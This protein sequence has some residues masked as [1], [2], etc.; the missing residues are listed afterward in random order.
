ML[1]VSIKKLKEIGKKAFHPNC[2]NWSYLYLGRVARVSIKKTAPKA[3]FKL[4]Q[5][6]FGKKWKGKMLNGGSH[7]PINKI[8]A[9]VLINS[10]LEYSAKKNRAN[11][12]A[13]YSTL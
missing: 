9:N 4:N 5:R 1:D 13:E 11:V 8:A 6:L 3:I 12:I 10:I 7:P 2:I